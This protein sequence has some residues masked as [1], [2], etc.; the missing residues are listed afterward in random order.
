MKCDETKPQCLRCIKFWGSCEGYVERPKK[1]PENR[2][3]FLRSKREGY[4]FIKPAPGHDGKNNGTASAPSILR[5]PIAG[6]AFESME[7][8]SFF[9]VFLDETSAAFS[10]AFD[11]PVWQYLLPQHSSN[12]SFI[13]Y[14][15]AA[16]GAMTATFIEVTAR[17][18][19]GEIGDEDN[20]L[21]YC[22]A[23]KT[24]IA[25]Y[26]RSLYHM[27]IALSKPGYSTRDALLSC[28]LVVAFEGYHGHNYLS[29]MQAQSGLDIFYSWLARQPKLISNTSPFGSPNRIEIEDDLAAAMHRLDL[30]VLSFFDTRPT[31]VHVQ[32]AD[33]ETNILRSMPSTFISLSQARS[34]S[35][36]ICNR[37]Y[38]LIA[39]SLRSSGNIFTALLLLGVTMPYPDDMSPP[40]GVKL[41]AQC[42]NTLTGHRIEREKCAGEIDAWMQAYIP[43]Y[44]EL[45]ATNNPR[46]CGARI[47]LIRAKMARI[48][49]ASAFFKSEMEYDSLLSEFESVYTLAASVWPAHIG[50]I[51]VSY[52][53]DLGL[54]PHLFVVATRCRDRILRRKVIKLLFSAFH[55][56]N[57]WDSFGIAYIARWV[58]GMEEGLEVQPLRSTEWA[59][60][61]EC[62][63][64]ETIQADEVVPEG[65]R[66]KITRFNVE[67][68]MRRAQLEFIQGHAEEAKPNLE[69]HTVRW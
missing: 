35:D 8:D 59:T 34:F 23:Y 30:Q 58:V 21:G 24:A 4:A 60:A 3:R 55:R 12:Q 64:V 11:D 49:L 52:N 63:N 66:V 61:L 32:L 27:K 45:T 38:H 5:Q 29:T 7:E 20:C 1:H 68:N 17:R 41:F 25:L 13:R 22:S 42:A 2:H 15:V 18:M 65:R 53:F 36:L 56:E 14:G 40:T 50:K 69:E 39:S 62:L 10:G 57:S 67:L 33:F 28:L 43:I 44:A 47:L 37:T 54:L 9:H 46:N 6:P 48:L 16:L 19:A 26:G 31:E 51:G